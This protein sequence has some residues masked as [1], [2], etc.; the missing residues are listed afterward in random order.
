MRLVGV[1]EGGVRTE[2]TFEMSSRSFKNTNFLS[3]PGVQVWMQ[4]S[5]RA[6]VL[7]VVELS[8]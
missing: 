4:A 5:W 2:V 8:P 7:R 3:E 6:R 1:G